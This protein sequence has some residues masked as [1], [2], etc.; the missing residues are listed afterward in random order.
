MRSLIKNIHTEEMTDALELAPAMKVLEARNHGNLI[1][2]MRN[3]DLFAVGYRL[4]H[5]FLLSTPVHR[6]SYFLLFL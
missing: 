2:C 4:A 1:L 3:T 6:V 5:P